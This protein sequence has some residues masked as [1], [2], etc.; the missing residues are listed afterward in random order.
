MQ[1]PKSEL[2]LG[3]F[4]EKKSLLITPSLIYLAK[5]TRITYCDPPNTFG[6]WRVNSWVP[7]APNHSRLPSNVSTTREDWPKDKKDVFC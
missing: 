7:L 3:L 1:Q 4:E 6:V 2:T 5:K